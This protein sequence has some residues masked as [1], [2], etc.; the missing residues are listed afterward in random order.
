MPLL[1]SLYNFEEISYELSLLSAFF[2]GFNCLQNSEITAVYGNQ[3]CRVSKKSIFCLINNRTKDF[4]Q[5]FTISPILVKTH[6]DL[7]F[8]TKIVE[9]R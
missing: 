5:N 3:Y 4:S 9:I 2:I 8:E 7:N 6:L 1:I